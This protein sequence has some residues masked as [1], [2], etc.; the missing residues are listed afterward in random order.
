MYLAFGVFIIACGGTH[1]VDVVTVWIPVY[2]L[3]A[4]LRAAVAS[5]GTAIL[6]VPLIPKAVALGESARVGRQQ[7]RELESTYRELAHAHEKTK[8]LERL[9]TQFFANVSHELR[10]PLALVLGPA[11]ASGERPR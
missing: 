5:V 8:E 1:F 11:Q 7:S 4:G 2:W 3:D 9:K 6:L 10:T